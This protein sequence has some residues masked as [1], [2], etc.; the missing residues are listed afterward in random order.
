MIDLK[1]IETNPELP[2]H[3]VIELQFHRPKTNIKFKSYYKNNELYDIIVVKTPDKL[4]RAL[5]DYLVGRIVKVHREKDLNDK[6][7]WIIQRL[8]FSNHDTNKTKTKEVID[9]RKEFEEKWKNLTNQERLDALI[10]VE[11]KEETVLEK[12]PIVEEKTVK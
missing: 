9:L 1:A 4:K 2:E 11:K 7:P 5:G 3:V 6:Y 8:D 10:S 12:E